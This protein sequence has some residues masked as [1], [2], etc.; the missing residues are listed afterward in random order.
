VNPLNRIL[1]AIADRIR[2]DQNT[3]DT[4][5]GLVVEYRPDGTRVAYLPDLP[6]I[7]AAYR[8][9]ILA[10][11]DPVDQILIL[12]TDPTR[13]LSPG[14]AAGFVAAYLAKDPAT[15]PAS[16]GDQQ[17]PRPTARPIPAPTSVPTTRARPLR[18][19]RN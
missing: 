11:P 17:H 12:R 6:R 2:G 19:A 16:H 8:A 15:T 13:R 7:A 1:T 3:R 14:Q 18:P 4:A 9:R 10:N 5:L